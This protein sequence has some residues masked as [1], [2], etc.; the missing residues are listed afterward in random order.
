MLERAAY[1]L[2]S[3]IEPNLHQSLR[4]QRCAAYEMARL[5]A[6]LSAWA[7]SSARS[8]PDPQTNLRE[9]P[10]FAPFCG[11]TCAS[12]MLSLFRVYHV[13]APKWGRLPWSEEPAQKAASLG[14]SVCALKD[15]LV[16][17]PA[18]QEDR[19]A[20]SWWPSAISFASK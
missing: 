19:A 4:A 10:F 14:C 3:T 16:A 15:F 17:G 20:A 11:G 9:H 6:V 7:D 1:P 12:L 2:P 5:T 13:G 18:V 8:M